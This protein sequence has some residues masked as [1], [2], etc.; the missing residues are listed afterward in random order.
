MLPRSFDCRNQHYKNKENEKQKFYSLL[1]VLSFAHFSLY[2][3]TKAKHV[4][5]IGLDGWGSYSVEKA[6]MPVVK[7]DG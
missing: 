1:Y 4:I 2:A 7:T 5:L 3:G 6:D